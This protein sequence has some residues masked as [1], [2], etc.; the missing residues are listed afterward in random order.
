LFSIDKLLDLKEVWKKFTLFFVL[1][2]DA[3][4]AAKS[5]LEK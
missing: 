1:M 2:R 4:T 5:A 3:A